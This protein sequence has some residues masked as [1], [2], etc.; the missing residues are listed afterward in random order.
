MPRARCDRPTT[1][2][3][4]RDNFGFSFIGTLEQPHDP[5]GFSIGYPDGFAFSVRP[6]V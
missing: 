6:T 4:Y 1:N 3:Y 5:R 2:R